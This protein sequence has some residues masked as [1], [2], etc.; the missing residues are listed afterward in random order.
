MNK[1]EKIYK[2]IRDKDDIEKKSI[3]CSNL[4]V[5]S[6]NFSIILFCAKDCFLCFT[7]ISVSQSAPP[8][9]FP[10]LSTQLNMAL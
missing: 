8:Y 1:L 3:I 10:F 6:P 7:S 5:H 9:L 4:Y 2:E